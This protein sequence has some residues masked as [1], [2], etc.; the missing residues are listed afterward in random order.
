MYGLFFA[1]FTTI[2]ASLPGA[3]AEPVGGEPGAPE[4]GGR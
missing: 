3:P 1:S 2:V 4:P